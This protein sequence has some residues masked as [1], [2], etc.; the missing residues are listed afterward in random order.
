MKIRL[1]LSQINWRSARCRASPRQGV[2]ATSWR[3][4]PHSAE[5]P[6]TKA[7]EPVRRPSPPLF[8]HLRREKTAEVSVASLDS[9]LKS[10]DARLVSTDT[11]QAETKV[12]EAPVLGGSVGGSAAQAQNLASHVKGAE[13]E[14][15]R[16]QGAQSSSRQSQNSTEHSATGQ[17]KAEPAEYPSNEWSFESD[18]NGAGGL[19]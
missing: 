1:K 7:A 14:A 15:D 19:R 5:Q 4:R 3:R 18:Q 16:S 13:K 12:V 2:R 8:R 9:I 10:F 6:E 17:I 11:Q